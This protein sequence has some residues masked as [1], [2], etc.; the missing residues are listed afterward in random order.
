M[1]SDTLQQERQLTML[2]ST[3]E[4]ADI[5]VQRYN[6]IADLQVAIN[7]LKADNFKE[8]LKSIRI[9][10]KESLERYIKMLK[11]IDNEKRNKDLLAALN[12]V[13]LSSIS[14]EQPKE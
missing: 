12:I 9:T 1:S 6:M 10:L 14:D 8:Q 5:D 3:I 7:I 11:A 13:Q 2:K 4:L